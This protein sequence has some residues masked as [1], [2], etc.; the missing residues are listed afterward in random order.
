MGDIPLEAIDVTSMK[1]E[2]VAEEIFSSI[3]RE[4]IDEVNI[5]SD[6]LQPAMYLGTAKNTTSAG[7]P[8]M[9]FEIK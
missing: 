3:H 2:A 5:P 4:V 7:R 8:S 9:V 1:S 6:C